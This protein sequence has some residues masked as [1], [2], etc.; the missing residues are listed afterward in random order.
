MTSWRFSQKKLVMTMLDIRPVSVTEDL[1]RSPGGLPLIL[2]SSSSRLQRK[3]ESTGYKKLSINPLLSK[4]LL[5]FPADERPDH[6][7]EELRKVLNVSSPVL[8]EDFEML[9]DPRYQIDVLKLFCEKA[10]FV[11]IAVRWPG[12]STPTKLTY[13]SPEDPDYQEFNC[14]KYQIRVV[15]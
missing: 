15:R 7:E 6:V 10:R 4:A 9:F 8:I 2:C 14:D 13:A 11:P 5:G 3:L 12:D 1:L